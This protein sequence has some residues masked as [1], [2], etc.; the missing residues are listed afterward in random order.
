MAASAIKPPMTAEIAKSER[1]WIARGLERCSPL[2]FAGWMAPWLIML[3]IAIS[4]WP[5]RKRRSSGRPLRLWYASS[6][7][8]C[9]SAPATSS[10]VRPNCAT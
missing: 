6:Q 9:A 3:G 8:R 10:A 2:V 1:Q 5:S 4:N 7:R